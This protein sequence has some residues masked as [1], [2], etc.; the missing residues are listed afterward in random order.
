MAYLKYLLLTFGGEFTA[1]EFERHLRDL[2]IEHR[3]TTPV[4][5]QSNGRTERF[6]RTLKELIQQLVNNAMYKWEDR[7]SEALH[8]GVRTFYTL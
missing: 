6:N 4:H 1:H 2:G 7:L 5:P 8:A 3:T